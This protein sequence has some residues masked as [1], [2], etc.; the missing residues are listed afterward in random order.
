MKVYDEIAVFGCKATTLFLLDNL[1]I[2]YKVRHLITISPD[3]GIKHEVADYL[4]LKAAAEARGIQVYQARY[5][6]L[7]HDDD[8]AYINGLNLDLAFVMGWQRLIPGD[9][10]AGLQIGAFGMHGSAVNLP[11]G[12]GRSPMNWS[13]I[14]GRKAFYT[15]LFR[16]DP[17]VDSGDVVDTFKFQITPKDT[18]ES[19]HFKNTLAMK[20]L[21][22]RNIERLVRNGFSLTK[23]DDSLVPTYYPKR[24]PQDS[25]IDW[26]QEVYALERFIRAV[27]RPFSGAYSY[28]DGQ[29]IR[30]WNAQVFDVHDFGYDKW[31]AGTI[32]A[33]FESGKFLVKC[34]GGLLLVNDYEAPFTP[35]RGMRFGNNGQE[36]KHFDRNTLGFFD[37]PE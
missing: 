12:R 11:L 20:Y 23:Q 10:L 24:S 5:Y 21:I 33:V 36:V 15:N 32:A 34:F 17:G 29:E 31:A 16:Y 28:V 7:K 3:A 8:L 9:I 13:I 14:E 18:A 1:N 37:L 4:D 22:E 27:T 30:I 26:D 6:S 2:P 35:E 25:L 19:M